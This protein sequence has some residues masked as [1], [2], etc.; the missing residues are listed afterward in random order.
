MI[1]KEQDHLEH[2]GTPRHSGRY[3]WGSGGNE[4]SSST[5]NRSFLDAVDM[6][7]SQGLSSTEIARGMGITTTQLRARTTIATTQQRQEKINQAQKLSD[8]GWSNSAIGRHMGINESSVRSLLQPGAKDKN[9]VL[10]ETS[11][12]LK[13]QVDEKNWVDIGRGV[14]AHLGISKDKLNAAVALLKEEGYKVHI[15]KREQA[16]TGLLTTYKVLAKPGTTQKDAWM[17]RTEIQQITDFSDDGG[18][19]YYGLQ[20]PLSVSSKRV[21]INYAE[22]GGTAAD[23]VIYVRPGVNDVSIGSS[24]YAQVRIAVDGT[25]YLKGMAVY[26]DDLP[27]GV[28]LVFNTNKSNTGNKKDAMKAME[29]DIHGNIDEVNPFGAQIRRQLIEKDSSGNDRVTSAM[30]II[31]EEGNWDKWSKNLSSQVLSKQNPMLAKQQLN[32]TYEQ[33]LNEFKSINELTNPAVRKKLLETF[34]DTTDSAAVHLQAASLPKQATRVLIPVK[35]M[36]PTEVF[37]PTFDNGTRVA[38]IRFPH[39]GTFEIP[40]LTVNNKNAEARKLIGSQPKDAIAIHHKVAEHLSGADFDG[41]YVLVIP[42]TNRAI[43]TT[44]PLEGLKGFDPQHYKIPKDSPVPHITSSLK[45]QEMGKVTNLIADMS[46]RGAN[47][48]EMARAVRHSMV[49]IDSEKHGLDYRASARDNG[50]PA[51]KAK[52]QGIPTGSK[53]PSQAGASTLI[54]RATSK[55]RVPERALRKASQGGPV[56]KTTGKKVYVETGRTYVNKKGETVPK[57]MEV[58]RLAI[59]DDAATLSSH[60][61][62]EQIYV[63][64]SNKLKALANQARK[65]AVS[66]KPAKYSPSAK[67]AYSNEVATLDAKLNLALKNAPLERQAQVIAETQVSQKRQ[68]NPGMDD[69]SLRKI[70]YQALTTARARTGSDKHKIVPTQSEWDAIQAGAISNH[71]LTNIL[72]NSDI[73]AVKK[74]ATPKTQLLMTS[75]KKLRAQSMLNSGYTQAEVAKQLGVSL[76]TLKNSIE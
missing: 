70:K 43:K 76:T 57:M 53:R 59:T 49:V 31:N 21:G 55:T 26:K 7:R 12:M 60:T 3:P 63:E 45:Q 33:R 58:K 65:E 28:D 4:S 2:Y 54:T 74:L 52:Y 38:L 41:D 44:P 24:H 9:N 16:G 61:R 8:K 56:D 39:A 69:E 73:E 71:K 75:T 64:H 6:M 34:A 30:N 27:E 47:P 1:I 5:R 32:M 68:A 36:K 72:K 11:S 29:K 42:N 10:H 18:R 62:I 25:H 22:D 66:T 46:I 20:P 50:I 15:L 23:G 14:E 37:A 51:L 17:H 19:S 67:T 13:K 48:D 40:E 35:S